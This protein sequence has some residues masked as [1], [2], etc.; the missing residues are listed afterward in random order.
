MEQRG[1]TIPLIINHS[2]A[3]ASVDLELAPSQVIYA[4]PPKVL[5]KH[6]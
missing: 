6:L 1:F 5:E 2:A 4:R 3:A